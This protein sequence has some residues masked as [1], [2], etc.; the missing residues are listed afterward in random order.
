MHLVY[1]STKSGN[2]HRFIQRL[3]IPAYRLPVSSTQLVANTTQ[4]SVVHLSMNEH[5]TFTLNAAI[6][7]HNENISWVEKGIVSVPFVLVTPTYGGGH[8][9]GA[10]PPQ[11]IR[12][13]NNEHNRSLLQGV[14][15]CGDTNFGQG[16]CSAGKIVADKCNVP[17]LAN[18]EMFGTVEDGERIRN[19]L[20]D[21]WQ[22]RVTMVAS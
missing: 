3:N 6:H 17:H 21:F 22:K 19:T 14:I 9:K 2:T 15:A 4:S 8:L 20:I 18:I 16:F 10:V 13:L 7:K 5:E 11:V 1:F 12:F